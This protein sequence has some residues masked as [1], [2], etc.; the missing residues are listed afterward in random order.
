MTARRKSDPPRSHDPLVAIGKMADDDIVIGVAALEISRAQIGQGARLSDFPMAAYLRHLDVLV[1]DVRSYAGD[2]GDRT[3]IQA[4]ALC[5]VLARRYGYAAGNLDH[6][7]DPD[8]TLFSS[9][10]DRRAGSAPSLVAL[11]LH[12]ANTLGWTAEAIHFPTR[13]MLRLGAQQRIIIDPYYGGQQL[14][15][16]ELRA[17]LKAE[18]GDGVELA[19][20]QCGTLS[21][22]ELLY[23]MHSPLKDR[24]LLDGDHHNALR[25][26]EILRAIDPGRAILWRDAGVLHARLEQVEEAVHALE[27]F[28]AKASDDTRRYQTSVLLQDLRARLSRPPG[29]GSPK[30]RPLR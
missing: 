12:V 4:E 19:F 16:H 29:L 26:T 6:E 24:Y 1:R 10:I 17:M 7:F 25:A 13:P 9:V 5:Q 15:P 21:S 28:L 2:D 27:V 30:I 3:V 8:D 22:R 20:E 14:E 23:H 11:Y 18:E